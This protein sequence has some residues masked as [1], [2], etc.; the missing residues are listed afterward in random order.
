MGRNDGSIHIVVRTGCR[1]ESR[2]GR[3]SGR[4]AIGINSCNSDIGRSGNYRSSL[5]GDRNGGRC[6]ACVAC[7][8]G[9]TEGQRSNAQR[10]RGWSVMGW[11]QR[12]A[13]KI[14]RT[15][16]SQ[17]G[18]NRCIG[19]RSACCIHCCYGNARRSGNRRQ[20][21]ILYGDTLIAGCRVAVGIGNRPCYNCCTNGIGG[22]GIVGRCKQT[23]HQ[24]RCRCGSQCHTRLDTCRLGI[25]IRR[26]CQAWRRRISDNHIL[27]RC[28]DIAV[29][30]RRTPADNCCTNREQGRSIVRRCQTNIYI[31]CYR[32]RT[33]YH[34]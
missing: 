13:D 16:T 33:E 7:A 4:S 20:S 3:I 2:N 27:G 31:I 14:G 34:R 5:V 11:N 26:N 19:G 28:A 30:I 29:G 17:E 8:I 22:R 18:G 1:K 15:R 24:I 21:G 12:T 9:G 10:Q 23:G 6:R 32:C 25:N